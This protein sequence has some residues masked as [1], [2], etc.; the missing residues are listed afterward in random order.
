MNDKEKLASY[1]LN[2]AIEEYYKKAPSARFEDIPNSVF[3]G[4]MIKYEEEAVKSE[5]L[6]I[7][8][9]ILKAQTP[10]FKLDCEESTYCVLIDEQTNNVLHNCLKPKEIYKD[11]DCI[12][13]IV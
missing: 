4:A 12:K 9:S 10:S 3:I 1:I 8:N 13:I 7:E 5:R 6:R 2:K 11:G